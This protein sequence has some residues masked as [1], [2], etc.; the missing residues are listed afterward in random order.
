MRRTK[1]GGH[2]DKKEKES[3]VMDNKTVVVECVSAP[4]VLRL[5]QQ[6]VS[7]SMNLLGSRRARA[8]S[9]TARCE[10]VLIIG[11][12][13]TVNLKTLFLPNDIDSTPH[14]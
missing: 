3:D 9:V 10:N 4:R 1:T 13:V 5:A 7:A 11:V 8:V 12:P 2:A 14:A 6:Q